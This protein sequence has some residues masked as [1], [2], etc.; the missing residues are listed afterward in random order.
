M[1]DIDTIQF[2]WDTKKTVDI[3][4]WI[5]KGFNDDFLMQIHKEQDIEFEK[6]EQEYMK[7]LREYMEIVKVG[8]VK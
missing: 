8:I 4:T 5:L 1:K 7:N 2:R 3:L 6:I